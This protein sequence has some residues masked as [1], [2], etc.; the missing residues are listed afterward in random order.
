MASGGHTL[1]AYMRREGVRA[2]LILLLLLNILFS[3][4]IWGNK[5]LLES[6]ELNS[7]VM[8]SGAWAGQPVP[9]SWA[10]TALIIVC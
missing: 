6:A 1:S 3:P 8:P 9:L 7:S 10:K 5:N 4:C 2:A